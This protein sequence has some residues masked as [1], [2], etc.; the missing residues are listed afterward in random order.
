MSSQCANSSVMVFADTGIVRGDVVDGQV[1][2]D[3]APAE[4]DAGRVALE[5]L[6]LVRRVAQLHRDGE[7]EARRA[8]ADA[9]DP[10]A[11]TGGSC[12]T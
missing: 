12:Q 3:D 5:D 2:E 10:H 7:I 11:A 8:A 1:G 4:G 6:D 9:G